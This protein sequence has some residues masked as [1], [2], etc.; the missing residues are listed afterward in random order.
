[1]R[2]ITVINFTPLK[3]KLYP[4]IYSIGQSYIHE[5]WVILTRYLGN[6]FA[7]V[8]ATTPTYTGHITHRLAAHIEAPAY[9]LFVYSLSV[10]LPVQPVDTSCLFVTELKINCIAQLAMYIN[11]RPNRYSFPVQND[12]CLSHSHFTKSFP[13]FP[14]N[15]FFSHLN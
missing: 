7:T 3:K 12:W 4:I 9:P 13:R 10:V 5:K 1:M 15:I 11:K 14:P 6:S 8:V 2:R